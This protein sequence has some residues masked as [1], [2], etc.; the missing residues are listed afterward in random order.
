[1]NALDRK[2]GPLAIVIICLLVF[3]AAAVANLKRF[4]I[5]NDEYNSWNRILDSGTGAPYSLAQTVGDV[6]L[7]S[8]QHGPAYFVALNIWRTLAGSELFTLRLL[9]VY[10]GLLALAVTY[11]LAAAVGDQDLGLT[12]F[13]IAIFLAY[14]LYYSHLARMYT[15]LPLTSGWL[16]W[17]YTRVMQRRRRPSRLAWLTL[18]LSA[19]LILY[20]HYFGIMLLAALGLYHLAFAA[21]DRRWLEVSLLMVGAGLL[22]A[23]WLPT[24]IFGFPRPPGR[25]QYAA[26]PAGFDSAYLS[27]LLERSPLHAADCPCRDRRPAPA[28]E[29][30]RIAC[31]PGRRHYA[32]A[33]TAFE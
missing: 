2:R 31:Q 3:Y 17:S 18:L 5:G 16:L 24:A 8:P 23:P 30:G 32:A 15:L 26:A 10:F 13:F 20:I 6:T 19:A 4:P 22:F 11:R 25:Y 12:A 29:A 21:K 14:L 27:P 9:S 28:P 33:D 7:E 1:M